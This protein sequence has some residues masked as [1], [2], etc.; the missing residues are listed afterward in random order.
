[1]LEDKEIL[2]HQLSV[3]MFL[4]EGEGGEVILS[5]TPSEVHLNMHG[6]SRLFFLWQQQAYCCYHCDCHCLQIIFL[7][8]H[9]P[10][11]IF[12]PAVFLS[13]MPF[14]VPEPL[15]L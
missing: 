11:E 8:A 6:S 4:S 12:L 13:C 1:M 9:I 7:L 14:H 5:T 15:M 2:M 3:I 10:P